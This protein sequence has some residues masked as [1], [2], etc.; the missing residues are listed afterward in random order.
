[1][2]S[3]YQHFTTKLSTEVESRAE[4]HS[5]RK[6]AHTRGASN[7]FAKTTVLTLYNFG[8]TAHKTNNCYASHCLSNLDCGLRRENTFVGEAEKMIHTSRRY[9]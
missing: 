8:A 4:K 9:E 1:M 5:T 7:H 3:T 6:D 2:L